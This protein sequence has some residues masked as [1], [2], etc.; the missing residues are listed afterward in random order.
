M[1][2]QFLEVDRTTIPLILLLGALTAIGFLLARRWPSTVWLIITG[3]GAVVLMLARELARVLSL[4]LHPT[5]RR[6]LTVEVVV[7]AAL[8]LA[9]IAIPLR[10]AAHARERRL[11]ELNPPHRST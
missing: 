10:A 8:T 11:E 4:D 5:L 3:V 6:S 1:E 2:I 7:A 9:A